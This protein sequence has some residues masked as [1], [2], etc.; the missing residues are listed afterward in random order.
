MAYIDYCATISDS[1]LG[2]VLAYDVECELQ[3]SFEL[4]GGHPEYSIDGVYID[5]QNLARGDELGK[6]VGALIA[7]QAEAEIDAGG[8]L[9]DGLLEQEGIVYRGLGSLDPDGRYVRVAAE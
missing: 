1:R 9:L 3:V 7:N 5:G 8:V 2:V 6:M 4:V